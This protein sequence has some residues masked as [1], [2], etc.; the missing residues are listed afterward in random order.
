MRVVVLLLAV[1]LLAQPVQAQTLTPGQFAA[2]SVVANAQEKADAIRRRLDAPTSTPRP[3]LTPT[4]TPTE[5]PT[6]TPIPSVTPRPTETQRP[7]QTVAPV[8][9]VTKDVPTQPVGDVSAWNL[10]W[11]VTLGTVAFVVFAWAMA[12]VRKVI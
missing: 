12:R 4:N 3:T 1:L 9:T 6:R 11:R 8:A 5:T 10:I 7:T 2:T